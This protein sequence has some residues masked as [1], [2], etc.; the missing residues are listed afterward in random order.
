MNNLH[1]KILLNECFEVIREIENESDINK[2]SDR[3][4]KAN[5]KRIANRAKDFLTVF[6]L[7]NNL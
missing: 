1:E 7:K 3:F 2:I 4:I 6:K 5:I